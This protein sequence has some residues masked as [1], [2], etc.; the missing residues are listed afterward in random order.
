M[1]G[2]PHEK[3]NAILFKHDIPFYSACGVHTHFAQLCATTIPSPTS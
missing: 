3:S 1:D 2:M